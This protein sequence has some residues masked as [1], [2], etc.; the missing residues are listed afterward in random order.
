MEEKYQKI[1]EA[2][3]AG[4]QVLKHYLGQLLAIEEKSMPADI[5][6]KADLE[7]EEAILKILKK[8][9]PDYNI[10]SEE[11]DNIENGSEYTFIIDPLD[12]SNNFVMGIP[13]FS[14]IIALQ[15]NK[16]TIFGLVYQPILDNVYYAMKGKGA[17]LNG[18]KI[19]VN[20]KKDT[21]DVCIS[22][23]WG[24][25]KTDEEKKL[26][27]SYMTKVVES[28]IRRMCFNW[29]VGI[30]FCLLASGKMEAIFNRGCDLYDFVAGKLIAK[31]AGAV[32]V[33]FDGNIEGDD[34]NDMFIT[35]N[36]KIVADKVLKILK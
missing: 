12:A 27:A 4:G 11:T 18:N 29:S 25:M 7:S 31:E 15:K 14:I 20:D 19:N 13:N 3:K 28:D 33:D 23:V 22:M 24:Y 34:S 26:N 36:N 8:E 6:T 21:K 5:R 17:F 16:E 10:H 35:A 9:F 32:V 2:A 30:D 1:I